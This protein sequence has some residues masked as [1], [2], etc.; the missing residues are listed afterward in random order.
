MY[1]RCADCKASSWVPPLEDD[2]PQGFECKSCGES[3]TARA[4]ERL[5]HDPKQQHAN[6]RKFAEAH[7]ID[8]PSAYTVLLGIAPL[9]R[10]VREDRPQID[11]PESVD[12]A[13]PEPVPV[14][15]GGRKRL[16]YDPGFRSAVEQG[17][18]TVQQ[19]TQRGKRDVYA[20]KLASRHRLPLRTAFMVADNQITI[21]EALQEKEQ[22]QQAVESVSKPKR[23]GLGTGQKAIA[24]TFAAV[25]FGAVGAYGWML[26]TQQVGR[27]REAEARTELYQEPNPAGRVASLAGAATD[28]TPAPATGRSAV[29]I[30][31]DAEGR[32]TRVDGPDPMSV[33][34]S[35]CASSGGMEPLQLAPATAGFSSIRLGYLR[36][37][38]N[39]ESMFAI[40]I[41]RDART[42]RW[43]AGDGHEP[44]RPSQ[45]EPPAMTSDVTPA[46]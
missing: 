7:Q 35:Y 19:A 4:D 13:L 18:L 21:R 2:R 37:F 25:L 20:A 15:T 1:V 31:T 10:M 8:L 12:D 26:W 9:E 42:R 34:E 36:D 3:F 17:Y 23:K 28:A 44:I 38:D 5:G 39:L 43:V 6:A 14:V 33:L 45:A 16:R 40:R 46:R 27:S 11:A 32:I 41:R 22:A 24:F 30:D 29:K